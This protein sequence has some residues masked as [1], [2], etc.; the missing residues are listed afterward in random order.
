MTTKE[1]GKAARGYF[2]EVK[3]IEHHRARQMLVDRDTHTI[4]TAHLKILSKF[5]VATAVPYDCQQHYKVI[6]QTYLSSD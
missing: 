3:G 5:G 1:E 6:S 4:T 2:S